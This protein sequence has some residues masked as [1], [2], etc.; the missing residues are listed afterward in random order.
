M[1][2]NFGVI[3]DKHSIYSQ[4]L[5]SESAKSHL[6]VCYNSDGKLIVKICRVKDIGP[7]DNGNVTLVSPEEDQADIT[8]QLKHIESIYPISGFA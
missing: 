3:R 8:I 4:L 7:E 5:Q 2:V 6:A 1:E